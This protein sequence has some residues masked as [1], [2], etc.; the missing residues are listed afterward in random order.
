[1]SKAWVYQGVH[2]V[3]KVGKAKA[4]YYVGWFDPEGRKRCQSCG[5]GAAGRNAAYKLREKRQAELLSGTYQSNSKKTWEEFRQEY[6]AKIA[7]GMLASTR[8]LVLEALEQFERVINPKRIGAIKTQTIDEYRSNRRG[9]RG[10]KK[11]DKISPATVN[12]ELRHLRAILRK[13]FKWGYLPTMPDF[14]F[15]KEPRKLPRYVAPGHFA[16]IYNACGVAKK[17]TGLPYPPADWWRGLLITGYM[18]GWRISE[19]LALRRDDVDLD[20]GTAITRW[21][22]NKGKRD[23]RVKLHPV[24]VE[25]LR[26]LPGFDLS[27]FPW[28][29]SRLLLHEQFAMIQEAAGIKLPCRGNHE[30]TRY[31][32]GFHDLRRAFASMNTEKLTPDTLQL[33]MRH[34]SYLTTQRYINMFRQVDA[35]VEALYVPDLTPAKPA[36][37]AQG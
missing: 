11:G 3:E 5:P 26:R 17:P 32:Y 20:E 33:L 10:K 24:V 2:Q 37:S 23:E 29:D 27:I 35:A 30:H 8:R 36:I 15:E 4:S 25:H 14:Q 28:K 22:D 31:C 21:Q 6:E 1:M 13:A 19:L 18:T 16:A 34:K 7:E 9:D 12:R